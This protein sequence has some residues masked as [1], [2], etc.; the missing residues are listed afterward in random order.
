M[1]SLGVLTVMVN[2]LSGVP[3]RKAVL[4]VSDGLPAT[5]GEELFQFLAELCGGSGTAGIGSTPGVGGTSGAGKGLDPTTVYDSLSL[6]ARSVQ[7]RLRP[8]STPRA[9]ASASS[10]R[11]SWPTPTRSR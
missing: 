6:D 5:P 1:Q 7:G 4:H 9:T 11:P 2:S 8:L 10:L 3:G